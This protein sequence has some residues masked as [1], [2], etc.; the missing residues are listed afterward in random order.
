MKKRRLVSPVL[1]TV[2]LAVVIAVIVLIYARGMKTPERHRPE[3]NI[4]TLMKKAQQRGPQKFPEVLRG[5]DGKPIQ[6]P[7]PLPGRDR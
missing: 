5:P 7:A 6:L 3:G 4:A 2:V 1:A